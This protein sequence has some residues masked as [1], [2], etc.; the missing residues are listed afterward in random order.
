MLRRVGIIQKL[1]DRYQSS[2]IDV[3][4]YETD[5]KTWLWWGLQVSPVPVER[6]NSWGCFIKAYDK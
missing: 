3:R 6:K 5:L 2:V 1:S 4:I